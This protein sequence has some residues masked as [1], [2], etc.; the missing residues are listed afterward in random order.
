MTSRAGLRKLV[1]FETNFDSLLTDSSYA[2]EDD[3]LN[4]LALTHFDTEHIPNIY[5]WNQFDY[6][7]YT[8]ENLRGRTVAVAQR[9][10]AQMSDVDITDV[11]YQETELVT[12]FG[13]IETIR[14]CKRRSQCKCNLFCR[15]EYIIDAGI[16]CKNWWQF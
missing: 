1:L 15:I 8:L 11:I 14:F 9:T 6:S 13:G 5:P 16:S 4:W 2:F 3:S 10:S 12:S 7:G